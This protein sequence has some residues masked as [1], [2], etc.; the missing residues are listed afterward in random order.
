M[1]QTS[2]EDD[3][4]QKSV[5]NAV[6][7]MR[8]IESADHVCEILRTDSTLFHNFKPLGL[9]FHKLGQGLEVRKVCKDGRRF[10]HSKDR[11]AGFKW[12]SC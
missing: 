6:R 4:V 2:C 9:L 3:C 12:L 5:I 10:V 7:I 8:G 11:L 1:Y